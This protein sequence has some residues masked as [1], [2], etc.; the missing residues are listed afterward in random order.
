MKLAIDAR[1]LSQ[2]PTGVGQ[3]LMAAVNVWSAMEPQWQFELLSHRPLHECAR[4]ALRQAGNIRFHTCPAPRFAGNG[5]WWLQTHFEGV[6][7]ERGADLL[8]GASG[9]L[10]RGRRL[11]ALLTV[12][13][14]VYLTLPDTMSWRSRCAYSLL[15]GPAIRTADAIWC[16]SQFTASE[17]RRHY[18]LRRCAELAVGSGLNPLRGASPTAGEIDAVRERYGLRDG[19]SLLFVGTLEPRKNLDFLLDLMPRLGPLGIKLIVVGCAGWG[20]S[21]VAARIQAPGFPRDAVHFC[22]YVSDTELRALY[23]AASLFVS[24]SLMEGFGLPQLEAMDAGLPVVV[25]A[26]SAL[27]EVVGDGGILV[28]GW[29]PNDWQLAILQALQ[30]RSALSAPAR[31]AAARHDMATSCDA[32]ARILAELQLQRA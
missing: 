4:D 5:L 28:S 8:W 27:P 13:D 15:A 7:R 29:D 12:H 19:P 21:D 2:R 17:V 9:V 16:V 30:D 22:D 32:V 26:N 20:R 23:H 31:T 10:P 24:T 1:S 11:P 18:P 25:A 3:Y 14:L 6:G